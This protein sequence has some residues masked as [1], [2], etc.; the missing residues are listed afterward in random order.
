MHFTCRACHLS[1]AA[2]SRPQVKDFVERVSAL[3]GVPA[4]HAEQVQVVHYTKDQQY[5]KHWDAFDRKTERGQKM[6]RQA[7]NRIVTALI[8]LQT[9]EEGGETDMV[10]L[11]L[12]IE[13][14]LGRLLVFHNC[15]VGSETRCAA[16]SSAPSR[17]SCGKRKLFSRCCCFQNEFCCVY[18]ANQAHRLEPCGTTGPGWRE[19]GD[20]LMVP[21]EATASDLAFCLRMI[22]HSYPP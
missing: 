15:H 3:V 18:C 11:G 22:S 6:M 2:R 14:L 13:P 4:T 12:R 17:P 10:N 8:Y 21:R 1:R 5:R 7:G 19:V 20:E 9:P 16:C